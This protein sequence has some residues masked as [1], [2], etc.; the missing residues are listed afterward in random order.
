MNLFSAV[1]TFEKVVETGPEADVISVAMGNEFCNDL[2]NN[3]P[4]HI[5]DAI[6]TY[7]HPISYVVF[8]WKGNDQNKS[9]K[10]IIAKNK[11]V[12]DFMIVER[13]NNFDCFD[14]ARTSRDFQKKVVGESIKSESNWNNLSFLLEDNS[15]H[16]IIEK[17]V[18]DDLV[19]AFIKNKPSEIKALT[20]N[21][22]EPIIA[23]FAQFMADEGLEV[24]DKNGKPFKIPVEDLEDELD[25]AEELD[26]T[27]ADEEDAEG[28]EAEEGAE[29]EETS[30]KLKWSEISSAVSDIAKDKELTKLVLKNL[31]KED[32]FK[33]ALEDKIVFESKINSPYISNFSVSSLIY[34][35]LSFDDLKSA[36][37]A[38]DLDD[39]VNAD[40]LF[41]DVASALNDKVGEEV[42]TNIPAP[43][44]EEGE[45]GEEGESSEELEAALEDLPE[46]MDE[47][48]AEAEEDEDAALDALEDPAEEL[49]LD[50]ESLADILDDPEA[51]QQ[52]AEEAEADPNELAGAID[53]AEEDLSG[54]VE[55]PEDDPGEVEDLV[56]QAISS[57]EDPDD[58]EE[59][60]EK[61][62]LT[63]IDDWEEQLSDRQQKRINAKGRLSKLKKAMGDVTPP[64]VEPPT[65]PDKVAA[66]GDG[67]A[68]DNKIDDPKSTLGN[69]K[70][71]SPKELQK[72]IDLFPKIATEIEDEDGAE[73]KA[74]PKTYKRT[75]FE[76]KLED[77]FKTAAPDI[78]D[79]GGGMLAVALSDWI[80]NNEVEE[81]VLESRSLDMLLLEKYDFA[82]IAKFMKDE[83]SDVASEMGYEGKEDAVLADFLRAVEPVLGEEGI[84]INGIPT[85]SVENDARLL[86][87]A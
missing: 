13:S 54:E 63:A 9:G 40:E 30:E 8:P 72:L 20:P 43:A 21:D 38:K 27:L 25:D 50:P 74:D 3:D 51:L 76:K 42:V 26:P 45:E 39:E 78:A 70:N 11:I 32:S 69:P 41:S 47:F 68:K 62:I 55:N 59:A 33:A 28:E 64:E 57:A 7:V 19:Q 58:D 34:E 5:Y 18:W 65:D 53:T 6:K 12:E 66:A 75:D 2:D 73:E 4:T 82:A 16:L 10:Q 83:L 36:G 61:A 23:P 60:V 87:Y 79:S 46:L 77:A 24:V 44:D 52:A 22:V 35:Q 37:G 31:E 17:V 86:S 56:D 81:V 85:S 15:Q 29:G 14:L 80:M 49:G 84:E 48:E 1:L 67:W 71:F